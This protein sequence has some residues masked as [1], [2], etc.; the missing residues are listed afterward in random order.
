MAVTESLSNTARQTLGR[1]IFIPV[2]LML[3]GCILLAPLITALSPQLRY[4]PFALSL[5]LFG[6]PHGAVDHLVPARTANATVTI[7]SM[8]SVG[9]LYFIIGGIYLGWWFLAPTSAAIVFV[10]M[11]LFHWGQG[12][13][14]ALLSFLDADHLPTRSERALSVITRG[15]MP[16][17]VPLI[18]HPASYQRVLVAFIELFSI[19]I[20]SIGFLFSSPVRSGVTAILVGLTATTIVVG[21][22]RVYTGATVRPYLIDAGELGLLWVFFITL[23]PIFAVGVYFC[24]WHS[25]R[26][27]AR[28]AIVDQPSRQALNSAQ[29]SPAI[30]RFTRDAAPLTAVALLFFLGLY[31]L[32]P[33]PPDDIESL[34]AL[35]LVGIAALTA[36]H[37]VIV[38]WMD[39]VQAIW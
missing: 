7:R 2:W 37:V 14:Y 15:A 20:I 5:L 38:S 35:Y 24:V 11:T 3:I 26:H 25:L 39:R 31:I 8:L 12:D 33:R 27:I 18:T 17:L 1:S 4:L 29:I 22:W 21:A 23:P 16:M 34:A 13:I 10:F 32:V 30:R 28:V 9:G 6:L 36:P 19:D